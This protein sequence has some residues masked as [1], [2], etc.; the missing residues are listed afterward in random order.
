MTA[1]YRKYSPGLLLVGLIALGSSAHAQHPKSGLEIDPTF[2]VLHQ[3]VAR[4]GHNSPIFGNGLDPRVPLDRV[5]ALVRFSPEPT[6]EDLES[7]SSKGWEFLSSTASAGIWRVRIPFEWFEAKNFPDGLQAKIDAT[8]TP[9]KLAPLESTL[10]LVG[11]DHLHRAPGLELT[12]K[13]VRIATL[14]SGIDAFHPHFFR[15]STDYFS[16]LDVNENGSFDPDVDAVDMN[17]DG[18]P[19]LNETLRFLKSDERSFHAAKDWLFAD[20][21]RDGAR[22]YGAAQGF[23][24]ES[25][26][27]GEP[28]FLVDDLNGDGALNPEEKLVRLG[29][30]KVERFDDG[31]AV[32][33]RG[34]NLAASQMSEAFSRA[35]HGTAVASILAGGQVKFHDRVGM[36]P[37]AELLVYG[38]TQVDGELD[39]DFSD[40]RPVAALEDALGRD[41]SI[42]L[43]EWTN[44]YSA[45]HDGSG[46]F[47]DIVDTSSAGG[48]L[49]V[50]PVGNLNVA[51]KHVEVPV[52]PGA[53]ALAFDV[54]DA[55]SLNYPDFRIAYITL[56]WRG[57]HLP[58]ISVESPDGESVQLAF[59]AGDVE[60]GPHRIQATFQRTERDTAFAR[61]YVYSE[62]ALSLGTWTI[63]AEG[64]TEQDVI[65]G[66]I[67]DFYSGW[68]PGIGW[69]EPTQDRGTVVYPSVIDSS[70]SVGAWGSNSEGLLGVRASSGRGPRLD[71]AAVVDLVAPD[72][73]VSAL[74]LTPEAAANGFTPG[75]FAP[76]GGTS[77]AAPHVAGALALL[78]EAQTSDPAGV[79]RDAA[80]EVAGAS[81]NAAGA[82]LLA[83]DSIFERPPGPTLPPS[84]DA[85]WSEDT[86]TIEDDVDTQEYALDFD[87]NGSIDRNW[88]SEKSFE[89]PEE[90]QTVKVIGR[91]IQGIERGLV[92]KR[93]TPVIEPTPETKS[94]CGC[95]VGTG[96]PGFLAL[97]LLFVQAW[98]SKIY[99]NS[100][101]IR[102]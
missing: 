63:R 74:A 56:S 53:A 79:L 49:H 72:N 24:D 14:D 71:G 64:F 34:E 54:P 83:L 29:A 13:G 75:W 7:L 30:S 5:G 15:A 88:T 97:F 47:A 4:Y 76:F 78:L 31:S 42:V 101:P 18:K 102:R 35:F 61:I 2:N 39:Q 57:P 96:F 59:N 32:W 89:I 20:L 48:V 93:D 38:V 46:P 98:L 66:R 67:S 44:P 17:S 28:I 16:W 9:I 6:K 82:G 33:I 87:Y 70:I 10:A 81:E 58:V 55:E 84:F 40:S 73:P 8:W 77:G 22:N 90:I 25:P 52:E 92:L 23:D 43:H 80:S 27:F 45:P 60:F 99:P 3:H 19:Q 41:V 50:M 100:K 21:N 36:A 95:G 12:G 62:G 85:N 86:L 37:D 51:G 1:T 69:V 91:S 26:A 94:G 68:K 65:F 11:A